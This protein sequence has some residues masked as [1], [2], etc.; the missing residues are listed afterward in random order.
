MKRIIVILAASLIFINCT[1]T[2]E[3]VSSTLNNDQF[4]N[5]IVIK[6]IGNPNISHVELEIIFENGKK[7]TSQFDGK[8]SNTIL[9][10]NTNEPIK[11]IILD[12]DLK[13]LIVN[14]ITWNKNI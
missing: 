14:K 12:P 5:N 3:K 10:V 8:Q 1:K 13:L 11:E 9:Q 4:E 6:K 7:L 2:Q